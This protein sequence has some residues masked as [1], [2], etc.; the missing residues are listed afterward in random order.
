MARS[1]GSKGGAGG[2]A[3]AVKAPRAETKKHVK[4]VLPKITKDSPLRAMAEAAAE[5]AGGRLK[6]HPDI[7]TFLN[8]RNKEVRG[9]GSAPGEHERGCSLSVVARELGGQG[10]LACVVELAVQSGRHEAS[11][12]G[13][14]PNGGEPSAHSMALVKHEGVLYVFDPQH[15]AATPR[16]HT[17]SPGGLRPLLGKFGKV[18]YLSGSLP[19]KDEKCREGVLAFIGRLAADLEAELGKFEEMRK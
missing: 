7:A 17:V 14:G 6:V 15:R 12:A 18:R 13:M 2:A 16:K 5:A 10:T 3:A 11:Y 9:G 19:A 4:M 8:M 1:K